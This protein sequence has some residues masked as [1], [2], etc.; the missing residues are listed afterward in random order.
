[1]AGYDLNLSPNQTESSFHSHLFD[2]HTTP[3]DSNDTDPARYYTYQGPVSAV[4]S[5]RPT[6]LAEIYEP[7]ATT[8]DGFQVAAD[9]HQFAPKDITVK[10]VGYSILVEA[11]HEECPD[12]HGDHGSEFCRQFPIPNGFN[13]DCVIPELSSDGIL[14]VNA[15]PDNGVTRNERELPM[16]YTKPTRFHVKGK[17][18]K[19]T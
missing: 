1:M 4:S 13:P 6:V 9:V 10:T 15:S 14:T 18:K 7:I 16:D 8:K 17:V 5:L 19:A 2:V 12:K 11:N 3:H